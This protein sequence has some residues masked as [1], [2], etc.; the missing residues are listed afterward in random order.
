[1]NDEKQTIIY[2]SARC[3][4]SSLLGFPVLGREIIHGQRPNARIFNL[5]YNA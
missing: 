3:I 2:T 1:M 4:E 5:L